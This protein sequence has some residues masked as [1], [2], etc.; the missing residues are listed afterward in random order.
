MSRCSL[1]R[2]RR[3]HRMRQT[4]RLI[5]VVG[6]SGAG[7]DSLMDALV[8]AEPARFVRARRTIDRPA[9]AGGERHE[10]VTTAA[11]DRMAASGRFALWWTAHGQRYG[12]R[13]DMLAALSEGRD[14]LVNVSRAKLADARMAFPDMVVLNVTASAPILAARLRGRGR[15]GTA[16]IAARL[17]RAAPPLPPDLAVIVVSNDGTLGDACAQALAGLMQVCASEDEQLSGVRS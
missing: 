7:K 17:A 3:F 10:A 2:H 15:E 11:F 4:G 5:A 16:G 14:V 9:D 6:P 1:R 8:L 12:I 13:P